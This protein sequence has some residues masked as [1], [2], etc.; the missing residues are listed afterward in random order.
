MQK[1]QVIIVA[2]GRG[3]RMGTEVPK[4]F[5]LLGDKPVLLHSMEA[6][7]EFNPDIKMVIVLPEDYML[8]WE[9]IRIKYNI[10]IDHQVVAGGAS[11]F[12]SVSNGLDLIDDEGLVGIH[13]GARPLIK[14][15]TIRL[16]FEAADKKNNAI[17]YNLPSDSV[18]LERKDT[19]V[20]IDRSSIRMIQTPQVFDTK[21][22]KQAYQQ[23]QGYKQNEQSSFTDDA[24]VFEKAGGKVHLV[25]CDAGNLK[26]TREG[27][28]RVAEGLL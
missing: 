8:E 28:M 22:L 26:I 24:S 5:L 7:H 13:D 4:Q 9:N 19:S 3:S 10:T 18:R 17:P 15:S 23:G 2:A 20:I 21:M 25:E 12:Q 16:L 11:R 6:F 1:N 14:A 27:D